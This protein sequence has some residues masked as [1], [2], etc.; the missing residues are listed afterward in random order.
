MCRA[1]RVGQEK[2]P[3][4]PTL[5]S[6]GTYWLLKKINERLALIRAIKAYINAF[7]V[8]SFIITIIKLPYG[9]LIIYQCFEG[10][11]SFR[12]YVPGMARAFSS[13]RLF[14]IGISLLFL[15]Y[16]FF[17][18]KIKTQ[19]KMTSLLKHAHPDFG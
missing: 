17:N 13:R 3:S 4:K 19:E 7:K 18:I 14:K 2:T 9:V 12:L 15:Q 16:L 1:R 10:L 5:L 8:H 11:Q 6:P